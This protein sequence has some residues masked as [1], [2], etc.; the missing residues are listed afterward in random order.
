Y[1]V[2]AQ[3]KTEGLINDH[4]FIMLEFLDEVGNVINEQVTSTR[5]DHTTDWK[6]V[7]IGPLAPP[8]KVRHLR[9]ACVD[10]AGNPPDLSGKVYFDDVWIGR[11]PRFEMESSGKYQLFDLESEKKIS[12]RVRG[13]EQRQ[14]QARFLLK[15]DDEEKLAEQTFPLISGKIESTAEWTLPLN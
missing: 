12:I 13:R 15:N 14:M 7:Q 1:V 9:I 3:I 11:L 8:A 6:L 4:A 10:E 5:V 2:R